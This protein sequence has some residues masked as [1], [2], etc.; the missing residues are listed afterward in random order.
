MK[1]FELFFSIDSLSYTF[2]VLIYAVLAQFDVVPTITPLLLL[3]FFLVTSIIAA[4]ILLLTL[5]FP[6]RKPFATATVLLQI[7]CILIPVFGLG[8]AVFRWFPVRVPVLLLVLGMCVGIYL[9][10]V[11]LLKYKLRKEE[12]EINDAIRQHKR[13]KGGTSIG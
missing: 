1:R 12:R 4:L 7:A 5:Y 13:E 2:L 9:V 8:G 10:V 6:G 11:A 3:E